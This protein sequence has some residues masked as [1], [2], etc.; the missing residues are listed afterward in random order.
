MGGKWT[1][2]FP[3]CVL[4]EAHLFCHGGFCK[5]GG[6]PR[7]SAALGRAK[8]FLCILWAPSSHLGPAAGSVHSS[9]ADT[10]AGSAVPVL[11]AWSSPCLVCMHSLS[12]KREF[13][14]TA[15]PSH[16]AGMSSVKHG[17]PEFACSSS[18]QQQSPS[19]KSRW[20]EESLLMRKE[21]KKKKNIDAA[22]E[23]HLIS[24]EKLR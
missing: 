7:I 1:P 3:V 8:P 14:Q 23:L 5:G 22:D 6:L 20:W 15:L 17:K 16:R 19:D 12:L 4:S 21:K 13:W 18:A 24:T 9:D 10:K 2:D 11:H